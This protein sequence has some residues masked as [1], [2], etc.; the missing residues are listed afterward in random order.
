MGW[1]SYLRVSRVWQRTEVTL[2]IG[3]ALLEIN[4]LVGWSF[5]RLVVTLHRRGDSARLVVRA[6]AGIV[7][8]GGVTHWAL[9]RT[10]IPVNA[11]R[12]GVVVACAAV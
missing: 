11:R 12:L 9:A 2:A 3:I 6:V 7:L 10:K 5:S 4:I 8:L 1:E